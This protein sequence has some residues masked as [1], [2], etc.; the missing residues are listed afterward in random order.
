MVAAHNEICVPW[1]R[2]HTAALFA[3]AVL[4]LTAA[5]VAGPT[6]FVE[7]VGHLRVGPKKVVHGYFGGQYKNDCNCSGVTQ[8]TCPDD[9]GGTCMTKYDSGWEQTKGSMNGLQSSPNSTQGCV[10][11]YSC[12][13]P[14]NVVCTTVVQCNPK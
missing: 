13:Q 10:G 9:N 1:S 7:A 14:F 12:Q 8:T 4:L 3:F 5:G 6:G 11:L 2:S